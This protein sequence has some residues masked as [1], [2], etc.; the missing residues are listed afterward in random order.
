MGLFG[1]PN[2]Q[3][4]EEKRDFIGL[5]KAFSYSKS[6]KV[7]FEAGEALRRIGLTSFDPI[8]LDYKKPNIHDAVVEAMVWIGEPSIQPLI[9]ILNGYDPNN[10]QSAAYALGKIGDIRAIASLVKAIDDRDKV[11]QQYVSDALV[12]N[13]APAVNQIITN[14]GIYHGGDWLRKAIDILVEIGD[15][16]A[17]NPLLQLLNDTKVEVR[18]MAANA[19]YELDWRPGQDEIGATY[20]IAQGDWNKC[21]EIGIPAINSL[22]SFI[23]AIEACYISMSKNAGK[24]HVP[25][26]W[27]PYEPTLMVLEGNN[28]VEA[29]KALGRIGAPA[30]E[31]L[32]VVIKAHGEDIYK[33]SVENIKKVSFSLQNEYGYNNN[34][35]FKF[36]TKEFGIAIADDIRFMNNASDLQ[37]EEIWRKDSI[38]YLKSIYHDIH[39]E[40]MEA[41]ARI[42]PSM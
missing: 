16:N 32:C 41:L 13:G 22:F 19:L 23:S 12:R 20:W 9:K 17:I 36:D 2:I 8:M 28:V 38:Y 14:L 40:A 6:K 31:S 34:D 35:Q 39:R 37:F 10:R 3:K 33:A 11:V 4:M 42:R 25:V 27:K 5:A 18:R 30:V 26:Q 21:I 24:R 7:Q 15:E 29:V 1:S